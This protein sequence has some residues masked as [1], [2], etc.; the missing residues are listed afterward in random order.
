MVQLRTDLGTLRQE[1]AVAKARHEDA[2]KRHHRLAVE[3]ETVQTER[4]EVEREMQRVAE[5]EQ[6]VAADLGR[7]EAR[8]MEV[9]QSFEQ[10][11]GEAATTRAHREQLRTAG[12]GRKGRLDLLDER[13]PSPDHE[14][15]RV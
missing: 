10:A 3:R 2:M 8:A 9:R 1:L 7:A 13:L 6:A 14:T 15:S 5:R 12:A 4:A 11:Q